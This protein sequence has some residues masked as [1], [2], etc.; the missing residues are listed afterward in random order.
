M[1]DMRPIAEFPVE[2]NKP[3]LLFGRCEWENY[4]DETDEPCFVVGTYC[5]HVEG[6]GQ[7]E[8]KTH[9]PY[10]AYCHATLFAF[11]PQD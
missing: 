11:L 8:I 4:G 5:G 7:F 6:Y 3:V 2:Y 1:I 9:T 10:D